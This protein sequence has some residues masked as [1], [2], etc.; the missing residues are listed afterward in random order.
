MKN[1][2]SILL[3]LSLAACKQPAINPDDANEALLQ[4]ITDKVFDLWN[5]GDMALFEQ[6]FTADFTRTTNGVTV[7]GFDQFK[8]YY[9]AVK[10]TYPDLK[11]TLKDSWVKGD[12]ITFI[13][14]A[15]GTN[16]GPFGEG[17]PG[18]GKPVSSDGVTIYTLED[19]KIVSDW[20][21]YDQAT[22]FAQAGYTFTPPA[23][24]PK[25]AK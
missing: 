8:A 21:V 22:A 13:W 4:S 23:A 19:S 15:A 2:F 16:A 7:K 25:A 17:L 5:N 18:T 3:F 20:T 1:K 14:N 10:T 24:A 12:K 6:V 11:L 9:A